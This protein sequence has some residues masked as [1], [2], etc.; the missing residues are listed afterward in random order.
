AGE[1]LGLGRLL[2]LA[3]KLPTTSPAAAGMALLAAVEEYRGA[4]PAEDDETL[5]ALQRAAVLPA[6]EIIP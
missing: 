3:Q 4:A 6:P 2:Q 5:I 1:R